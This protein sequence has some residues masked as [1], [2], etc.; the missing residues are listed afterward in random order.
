VVGMILK[1]VLSKYRYQI[2]RQE[3]TI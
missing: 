2:F 3:E 1:T